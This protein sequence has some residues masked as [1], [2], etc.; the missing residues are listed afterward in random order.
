MRR[1]GLHDAAEN[2]KNEVSPRPTIAATAKA[3][4]DH[5]EEQWGTKV[6]EEKRS[7]DPKSKSE[8]TFKSSEQVVSD[9]EDESGGEEKVE[10]E[11]PP[12]SHQDESQDQDQDQE[13]EEEEE[14]IEELAPVEIPDSQPVNR[15]LQVVAE[16]P[17]SFKSINKPSKR[18][19]ESA[20]GEQ[21]TAAAEGS[22]SA[23]KTR[24]KARKA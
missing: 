7:Y 5:L 17:T 2:F 12:T 1:R 22:K 23:R 8:R 16:S 11:T 4:A 18:S 15:K 20:A 3:L 19:V 14:E 21:A 9:G 10:T 13:E 6:L 24:A